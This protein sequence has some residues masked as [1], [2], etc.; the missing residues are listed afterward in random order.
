M[1]LVL[2][3]PST[4]SNTKTIHMNKCS[5]MIAHSRLGHPNDEYYDIMLVHNMVDGLQS[6]G[7][8]DRHVGTPCHDC[9]HGHAHARPV[10]HA[11]SRIPS[12]PAECVHMDIGGPMPVR[13]LNSELYFNMAKCKYLGHRVIYFMKTKD[14]IVETVRQYI[15]ETRMI[16]K[17][18]YCEYKLDLIVTDSD[19]LYMSSA[20]ANLEREHNIRHWF[21]SPY[22][23]SQ[24]GGI[25]SDM[26]VIGEGA[27]IA[28]RSSG[29]PLCMWPYAYSYVVWC[30]NRSYTKIHYH[31]DHKYKTPHERRFNIK[32]VLG[33]MVVFGAKCWVYIDAASRLKMQ[34]HCWVGY[35]CGYPF[36]SKGYLCYDPAR[37][38]VYIRYHVLFDERVVYGDE[39]GAKK[40]EKDQ[41][42]SDH[43]SLVRQDVEEMANAQASELRETLQRAVEV[44]M[45]DDVEHSV[46]RSATSAARAALAA[47]SPDAAAAVVP[48]SA[49]SRL[50]SPPSLSTPM[51]PPA[52]VL[53]QDAPTP[54]NPPARRRISLQDASPSTTQPATVAHQVWG[55][56]RAQERVSTRSQPDAAPGVRRSS[57]PRMQRVQ[58]DSF[59]DPV[60]Q[61]KRDRQWQNAVV[62]D[63][64]HLLAPTTTTRLQTDVSVATSSLLCVSVAAAIDHMFLSTTSPH[65]QTTML[66]ALVS[67]KDARTPEQIQLDLQSAAADVWLQK[68][69][70]TN[71]TNIFDAWK[72]PWP[73][74]QLYIEDSDKEVAYIEDNGIATVVDRYSIPNINV[75]TCHW[76]CSLKW[77]PVPMPDSKVKWIPLRGRCRWVPHGNKQVEGVDYDAYGVASPVAKIESFFILFSITVQFMLHTCLID[78]ERAFY[79]GDLQEDVYVD[80]PP[81]YRSG[82][83]V[84]QFGA[85][86]SC[87]KLHKAVNGLKQSGHAYY[88]K[89]RKDME[90]NGYRCLSAD[91]CVFMRIAPSPTPAQPSRFASLVGSGSDILIIALWVDDNKISYS[92]PHMIEHFVATLRKCGYGFRNLGEWKYSLGM[93]VKYDRKEGKLSISHSSYLSTFFASLPW[94][95]PTRKVTP[96]RANS[97]LRRRAEGETSTFW[98]SEHFRK[99]L[100][101]MAHVSHWTFPE[102]ALTISMCSQHMS[103]PGEEHW[104]YLVW[105]LDYVY[106][107]K[108]SERLFTR[109]NGGLRT[110]FGYC[111]A[112]YAGDPDSRRSRTG[113]CFFLFGNLISHQSKLQH[114]VTLRTCEA[115][116]LAMVAA[117]QFALWSCQLLRELGI[118]L[119][120]CFE[121]YSDNKSALMV[122]HTPVGSR[123]TKHIDVRLMFLKELCRDRKVF[124]ILFAES[125]HNHANHGT[126]ST[127]WKLFEEVRAVYKG[128]SKHHPAL[129]SSSTRFSQMDFEK[130]RGG[131]A[132]VLYTWTLTKL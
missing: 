46:H 15:L 87:W 82:D 118:K 48:S 75:L 81:G 60:F 123:Y 64:P 112:D 128:T 26:R 83:R 38:N 94:Y 34:D 96:A 62:Q 1:Q 42:E 59:V 119:P 109:C 90:A 101:A 103:N 50:L 91:N 76:V 41:R 79:L 105:I 116:L 31:P 110:Y 92:A 95:K 127:G 25:E 6:L 21:A 80:I 40:R 23:H 19:K 104:D 56:G 14:E 61:L 97:Q 130:V 73:E 53:P 16:D 84:R 9:P 70:Y 115:E 30:N 5:H 28:I 7:D 114:C 132:A 54:D 107:N 12:G 49:V 24:A 33:E 71:P 113:Y 17:Q 74:G 63:S 78:I 35:F 117:C 65:S 2:V 102:I 45:S 43:E 88:V 93:D 13:G 8:F 10:P 51:A 47:A 37:M 27:I 32:P 68:D 29:F 89:V 58:E 11:S 4:N 125:A 98:W 85:A 36:N 66:A 121:L 124:D 100:G 77:Q 122:A 20:F 52:A 129:K 106:T 120:D 57:R 131:D 22:T 39:L 99:C 44:S 69:G 18:V 108:D 3:N 67:E 55:A 72:R 111:D 86:A 126:K